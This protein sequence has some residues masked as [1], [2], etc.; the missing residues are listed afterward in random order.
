MQPVVMAH[1]MVVG[2]HVAVEVNL[3][4]VGITVEVERA[5]PFSWLILTLVLGATMA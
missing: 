3:V 4:V 2:A 5:S 1:P